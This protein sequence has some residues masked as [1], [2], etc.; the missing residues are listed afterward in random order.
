MKKASLWS[1]HESWSH[2]VGCCI[3]SPVHLHTNGI[4]SSAYFRG[5]SIYRLKAKPIFLFFFCL[6]AGRMSA[7]CRFCF[8]DGKFCLQGAN[9]KH[10]YGMSSYFEL[11]IN[12]C[13]LCKKLKLTE[14]QMPL[15][16]VDGFIISNWAPSFPLL[17]FDL[18][19][20]GSW[21]QNDI[22]SKVIKGRT[23]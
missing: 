18:K 7:N 9:I 15:R 1:Y 10:L 22:Q 8:T 19:V 21:S 4:G 12:L 6:S 3:L 23:P 11:N 17:Q 2:Y 13:S 5:L 20:Q 16:V 14:S